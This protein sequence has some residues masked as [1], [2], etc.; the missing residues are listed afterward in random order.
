MPFPLA[1]LGGA[2][3]SAIAGASATTLIVGGVAAT[4][5]GV[6]TAAAISNHNDMKRA[7]AREAAE[8][9]ASREQERL[10]LE[11]D[12]KRK[13][14]EERA[15]KKYGMDN[16]PQEEASEIWAARAEVLGALEGNAS[17]MEKQGKTVSAEAQ[18]AMD[19]LKAEFAK[20]GVKE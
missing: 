14:K 3:V 7:R 1:A 11:K 4:A 10:I 2:I 18:A 9:E 20:A 8:R 19:E 5:A 6:F 16:I 12:R 15:R 13:E 17:G